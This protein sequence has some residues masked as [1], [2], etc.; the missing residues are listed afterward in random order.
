MSAVLVDELVSDRRGSLVGARRSAG[1][2][3]STP[4]ARLQLVPE[5]AAPTPSIG[6]VAADSWRLTDR[7]IAVVLA[8]LVGLFVLGVVVL[9]NAFLAV[10]E[11]PAGSSP[12]SVPVVAALR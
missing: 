9:V 3:D 11:A 12:S 6:G 10:P 2:V 7:G 1:R 5:L 4:R 8:A